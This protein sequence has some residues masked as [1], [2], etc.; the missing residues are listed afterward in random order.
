[1][2]KTEV[3]RLRKEAENHL[4]EI[5]SGIAENSRLIIEEYKNLTESFRLKLMPVAKL[6]ISNQKGKLSNRIIETIN[7]GKDYILK[8]A[9]CPANQKSRLI[10][11]TG[12][13]SQGKKSL[14]EKKRLD[15]ISFTLNTLEQKKIKT[16]GL[17]NSLNILDPVNVLKRGYTITMSDKRIIKSAHLVSCDD[18]IDTLFGD[19]KI[20]SRVVKKKVEGG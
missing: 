10:S 8:A 16:D 6:M 14:I 3:T 18:I 1:M 2:I 17:G 13:Y 19:G 9:L 15:L 20:R 11:L 12:I 4:N 5:I 7:F